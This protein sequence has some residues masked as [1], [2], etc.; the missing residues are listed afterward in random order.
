MGRNLAA[1]P[2][3]VLAPTPFA[4]VVPARTGRAVW[5]GH[6]YWSQ[7]YAAAPARSTP[8]SGPHVAG[9]RASVR[10]AGRSAD[11]ARG[12]Q[13]HGDLSRCSGRW[14]APCTG[15]A[16]RGSICSGA[17]S[18]GP[19]AGRRSA[20]PTR[21]R[22]SRRPCCRPARPPGRAR[23][24]RPR[25]GRSSTPEL[26]FGQAIHRPPAGVERA[27]A[28]PAAGD[29][30][31]RGASKKPRSR[32]TA[33]R[34]RR[35]TCTP[36]G[37]SPSVAVESVGRADQAEPGARLDPELADQRGARVAGIDRRA[38]AR[39]GR[40]R[41]PRR[42]ACES[43]LPCQ[44]T[45][46]RPGSSSDE[47]GAGDRRGV[48]LPD[49][50]RV[51]GVGL[52]ARSHDRAGTEIAP[53]SSTRSNGRERGTACSASA[54]ASGCSCARQPLAD[55]L[56]HRLAPLLGHRPA[57]RRRRGT[58]DRR[59]SRRPSRERVPARQPR[60]VVARRVVRGRYDNQAR[61]PLGAVAAPATAACGRP[62]RRPASTARSMPE[63]RRA[64]PRGRAP[65]RRSRSAG[66][67]AGDGAAVA[68]RV[69]GDHA[70]AAERS[71]A[72]EP[73]TT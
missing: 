46:E 55:H 33:R 35:R 65:S 19:R 64:P 54:T 73:I 30:A 48:G 27:R 53:S 36:S 38:H 34:A 44:A 69:V 67:G 71:S 1:P 28:A 51:A 26:R 43:W 47:P 68:A 8:C 31:R 17:P 41:R 45:G 63:R 29:R 24:R 52:V 15:S 66:I 10:P 14:S 23:G 5:V 3:G 11:A 56:D 16:A 39:S 37:S 60:R 21:S 25:R 6:G 59:R 22:R 57:R 50:L 49:R 42:S 58:L 32:R 70:V 62:S 12:L 20:A 72:V 7:D 13:A 61:H 9:S 4:A 2:G 40:P 18:A